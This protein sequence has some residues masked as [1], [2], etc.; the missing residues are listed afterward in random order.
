MATNLLSQG[1]PMIALRRRVPPHAAGQQQRLLPG[2]RRFPGST[3]GWSQRN[4]SLLRFVRALM[5]FRRG[6]PTMRR[7]D[8]LTGLPVRPG[9]LPDVSWY[10]PSGDA[11]RLVARGNSL[12]CILGAV[13]R[14]DVADP[15]NHHLLL[16]AARA[17]RRRRSSSFPKVVAR[18]DWWQF[19]DTGGPRPQDIYP[20]LDGP[21]PPADWTVAL[22]GRSLVCYIARD[23]G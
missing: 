11:D 5:A 1:V 9:G 8:F 19:I 18:L 12:M 13:P 22:E 16:H 17:A 23:E 4:E 20:G 2:Q 3:G 6:E 15:P 7:T 21:S 10:G 14:Q